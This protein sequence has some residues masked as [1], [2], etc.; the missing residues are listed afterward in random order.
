MD[1]KIVILTKLTNKEVK[2]NFPEKAAVIEYFKVNFKKL[3]F[4][5]TKQTWRK[6]CEGVT[7]VCNIQNSQ[8][9]K[10][11]YYINCGVLI[12]KLAH[13]PHNYGTF[14]VRAELFNTVEQTFNGVIGWLN[15][16]D[17]YDKTVQACTRYEFL[18]KTYC[19]KILDELAKN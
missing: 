8:W 16:Y 7:L 1:K 15:K 18:N 2:N 13:L 4:L 19:E 5:K 14:E 10:E 3:G 6:S 9:S 17:T 11:D 12:D